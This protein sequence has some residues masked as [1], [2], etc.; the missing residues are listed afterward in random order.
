MLETLNFHP[1]Y[2]EALPQL[3]KIEVAMLGAY[4]VKLAG[5]DYLTQPLHISQE[6]DAA[7]KALLWSN[8]LSRAEFDEIPSQTLRSNLGKLKLQNTDFTL[9]QR[10][11]YL[12]SD[13]D[14]NGLSL[15]GLMNN[16][17]T[18]VMEYKWHLLLA[19]HRG[20]SSL[21][22]KS[23]TITELERANA[24]ATIKQY[25][26]KNVVDWHFDRIN[27]VMQMTYI[28]LR[29]VGE[30]F[31]RGSLTRSKI[32]S[33]LILAL[34]EDGNYYQQKIVKG[35]DAGYIEGKRN[36]ISVGD[37]PLKWIP[38]QIIAD[39]ELQAGNLPRDFGMLSPI[40]DAT[41]SRYNVSAQY[42]DHQDKLRPTTVITGM[43]DQ[44]VEQYVKINGSMTFKWG[45]VNVFGGFGD[46]K[47]EIQI[48]GAAD[49]LDSYTKYFEDNE[50]KI[51]SLGGIFPT[52]DK[53]ARTATEVI[54][55]VADDVARF[56]PLIS[57]LE[58]G[59]KRILSYCAMFEGLMS[60]DNI[61]QQM[62]E[63]I[64]VDIPAE[65]AAQRLTVE[66]VKELTELRLANPQ[67]YT[68]ENVTK[69]LMA[70]GWGSEEIKQL[71]DNGTQID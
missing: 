67:Y 38:I 47:P 16:S 45:G 17:A 1:E 15:V 53:K 11:E 30:E 44:L 71:L 59:L 26:R 25:D 5:A 54:S 41:V 20:L 27:G 60:Q 34:D 40:V 22:L 13:C 18:A 57:S 2:K 48:I 4:Y 23:A 51:R 64:I 8:Y 21:A 50:K 69:I 36:Y 63:Q 29:E 58:N 49:T 28:M 66:E 33:F 46:Q 7:K 6:T 62:Q 39:E 31:N 55:E 24:R 70:G 68:E 9:P 32:E 10:I 61:E 3:N 12:V 35:S 37:Q 52:N 43:T 19:D 56:T 65:F 14:L 42:K